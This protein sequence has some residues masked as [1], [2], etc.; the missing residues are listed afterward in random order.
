MVVERSIERLTEV[1]PLRF[2]R[3]ADYCV[4]TVGSEAIAERVMRSVS[5]FSKRDW[6]QG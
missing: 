3:Y 6:T 5:R 2:V 1:K 4:I